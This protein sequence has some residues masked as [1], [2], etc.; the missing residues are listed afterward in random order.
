M[1]DYPETH[2]ERIKYERI[3]EQLEEKERQ[4]QVTDINAMKDKFFRRN[5]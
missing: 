1:K 3:A 2:K 5:T 4:S